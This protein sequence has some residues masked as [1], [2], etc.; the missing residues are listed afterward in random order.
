M[1]TQQ[2]YSLFLWL[3]IF[4]LAGY[5]TVPPAVMLAAKCAPTPAQTEGP[6]YPPPSQ[7]AAQVDKDNDLTRLQ[8][9]SGRVNGQVIYILGQVRDEECRP[10]ESAAVEIW[11]A[12]ASGRYSHPRDHNLAPLDAD[13][14]FWGKTTTDKDGRYQFK[15]V[16]PGQYP[17]GPRWIRPSHIHFRVQRSGFQDLTT[18]M[19]FQ[20][21]RYQERDPI[22]LRVP[23]TERRLVIVK[24]EAP[25]PGF[26]PDS[27][28]CR[29]DLTLKGQ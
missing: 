29:F 19:Y 3:L 2:N 28:L 14:Q 23:E 4:S 17:A 16:I 13:F 25:P 26:D 7:L 18:Q 21:D 10:I 22:F 11:Q 6:F 1:K 5:F 24:P 15:T 20:G 27:R 12:G 8:G 9:R